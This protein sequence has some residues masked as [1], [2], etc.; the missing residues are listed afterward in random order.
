MS[1]GTPPPSDLLVGKNCRQ[2]RAHCS[3]TEINTQTRPKVS[4]TLQGEQA[5]AMLGSSAAS[6]MYITRSDNPHE[7]GLGSQH[8]TIGEESPH[9]VDTVLWLR[10]QLSEKDV[11][12]MQAPTTLGPEPHACCL[13]F[14]R[15]VQSAA[16]PAARGAGATRSFESGV[17]DEGGKKAVGGDSPPEERPHHS[18]GRPDPEVPRTPSLYSAP[19]VL[20]QLRCRHMVE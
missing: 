18:G 3:R 19:R 16:D 10:K 12:I 4:N 8:A 20:D 2:R 7:L 5:H 15:G 14:S 17:G 6:P 1:S 13:A 9:R 11:E